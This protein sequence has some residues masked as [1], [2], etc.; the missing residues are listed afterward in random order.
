MKSRGTTYDILV[1]H[2]G[3]YIISVIT[4]PVSI[5]GCR[6]FFLS[7]RYVD[8]VGRAVWGKEPLGIRDVQA[9]IPIHGGDNRPFRF[10][11]P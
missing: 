8:I 2:Y 10:F 6:L 1:L 5:L 9:R 3:M 11:L 4:V 7:R